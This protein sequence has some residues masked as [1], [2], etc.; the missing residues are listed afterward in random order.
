M[1]RVCLCLPLLV[2]ALSAAPVSASTT[3]GADLGTGSAGMGISCNSPNWVVSSGEPGTATTSGCLTLLTGGGSTVPADGVLVSF[4]VRLS[5]PETGRLRV[6]FPKDPAAGGHYMAGFGKSESVTVPGD[7]ATHTYPVRLAVLAGWSIGFTTPVSKP[8]LIVRSAPGPARIFIDLAEENHGFPEYDTSHALDGYQAPL[9]AKV[10]PDA[11]GDGFGDETQDKCPGVNGTE[12]GCVPTPPTGGGGGDG[13]GGGSTTTPDPTPTGGTGQPVV[14][15]PITPVVPAPPAPDV[16]APIVSS[17]VMSPTSFVAANSGAPVVAAKKVG[18]TIVY[19]LS[20]K[21]TATFA[22]TQT[23]N[24]VK[25]GKTCVAGKPGHGK[26]K[27]TR[28]VTLGSFSQSGN[29]GLNSFKFM[30]RFKRALK[31]GSYALVAT[32]TDA[33]GNKSKRSSRSFKIVG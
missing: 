9:S 17:Y 10:E 29:S 5:T 26:R 32:A 22:V 14:T 12:D 1:R 33:A 7:G 30:G 21:A 18:T 4:S 24:G 13:T 3:F 16:V 15:G 25:K 23:L 20:E 27:C 19:K 11:D 31:K 8:D 6:A 28:T 2:L